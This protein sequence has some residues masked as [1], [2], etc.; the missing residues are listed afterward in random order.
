MIKTLIAATLAAGLLI[1][2]IASTH[3]TRAELRHD[4]NVIHREHHQMVRAVRTNHPKIAC[5][6]H[7]ELV[8]ARHEYRED[9][10]DWHS[11]HRSR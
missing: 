7:R 9:R 10:R 3:T 6:E 4:R 5:Q 2:G 11:T 1:P 8:G